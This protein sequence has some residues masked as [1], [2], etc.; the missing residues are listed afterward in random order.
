MSLLRWL[1]SAALVAFAAQLVVIH[2]TPVDAAL[3]FLAIA[4]T[5]L[6][7]LSYPGIMIGVPLLL[8]SE[9][10]IA[11]ETLRLLS[12]GVV[13]ACAFFAA[14]LDRRR[15]IGA[16]IGT[17]T[18]GTTGRATTGT[19]AMPLVALTAIVILRW[20]PIGEVRVGREL[21]LL[22]ISGAIVLVLG[23]TPLAAAIA[24]VVALFTHL[25]PSRSLWLPF[26]VLVLAVVARIAG[27][28]RLRLAWPSATI[29]ATL[30]LFFAWS[31]VVVRA[32]PWLFTNAERRDRAEVGRIVG[33]GES[34]LLE[35]PVGAEALIVSGAHVA[36]MKDGTVL[37]HL[38]PGRQELVIG[39]LA[40]W[41]Y[42]R[43]EF[44]PDSRNPLPR[45]SAGRVHG[46]GYAAWV[47]GAGR[48]RLPKNAR[49]IRVTGD[50]R[51]RGAAKLQIEAFEMANR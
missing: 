8:A 2:P 41:G 34:L 49:Q 19:I 27:A 22:V 42:M 20:I 16:T 44:F 26:F 18:I 5:L 9:I 30:V 4:V 1:V 38:D 23:S 12:F 29:V 28:A 10:A 6:A 40:D 14:L 7:A 25:P 13:M 50:P 35:V 48:I 31:G 37:G 33:A 3:P 17:A 32:L 36:T 45:D 11:D 24:V 51:L 43:R 39:N 15:A 47:D 46:Y 21:L